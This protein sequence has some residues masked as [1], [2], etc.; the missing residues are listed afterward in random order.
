MLA[1]IMADA[2]EAVLYCHMYLSSII[3]WNPSHSGSA[4][5]EGLGPVGGA[6]LCLL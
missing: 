4:Y 3:S 6:L 1:E 2:L 5:A